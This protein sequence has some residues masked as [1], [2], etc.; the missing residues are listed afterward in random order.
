MFEADIDNEKLSG[1]DHI[2]ISVKSQKA[3]RWV[4][5]A[6]EGID[7]PVSSVTAWGM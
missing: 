2:A 1:D 4:V 5:A 6:V 3:E 7:D